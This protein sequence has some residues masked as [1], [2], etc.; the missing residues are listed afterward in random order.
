MT[1]CEVCFP[2]LHHRLLS[3]FC[4]CCDDCVKLKRPKIWEEWRNVKEDEDESHVPCF[5]VCHPFDLRLAL[6][7]SFISVSFTESYESLLMK[8]YT[9]LSEQA[10]NDILSVIFLRET[11]EV[12]VNKVIFSFSLLAILSD[13]KTRPF[14]LVILVSSFFPFFFLCLNSLFLF[15]NSHLPF[16]V[17]TGFLYGGLY[18]VCLSC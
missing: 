14:Q 1:P 3:S 17:L 6:S 2:F 5:C 11:F 10:N 8:D 4:F 13:Q 15:R 7:L 16:L 9:T 18:N 12:K